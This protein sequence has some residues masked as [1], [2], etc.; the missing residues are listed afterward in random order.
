MASPIAAAS[1]PVTMLIAPGGSPAR[2][3]ITAS[4]KAEYGVC[5]AGLQ[6][7]VQ[8]AASA[9]PS[10]RPSQAAGKFQGVI[11]APTPSGWRRTKT[12]LSADAAGTPT[13]S[14]RPP[15]S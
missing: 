10:L 12:L 15:L 13:P 14:L 2:S 7:T 4:A 5:N 9:G 8:P 1:L 6:T 3:P 11:A